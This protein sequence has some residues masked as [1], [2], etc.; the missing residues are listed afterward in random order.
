[1]HAAARLDLGFVVLPYIH[2]AASAAVGF[3]TQNSTPVV[4]ERW[5]GV[6]WSGVEWSGVEWSGV[7]W[8]GAEWSGV[9]WS[10]VE[11]SRAGR[12]VATW[13]EEGG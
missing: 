4:A 2:R 3:L 6:E 7:E 11:W 10:G 9:E 13:Q 12:R 1:M 8:S 5:S